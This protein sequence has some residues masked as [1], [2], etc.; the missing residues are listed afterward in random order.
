M[1]EEQAAEN[2][3]T[4][5]TEPTDPTLIGAEAS[6]EAAET[7]AAPAPEKPSTRVEHAYGADDITV[8]AIRLSQEPESAT[9]QENRDVD[10]PDRAG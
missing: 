6:A 1:A 7:P 5:P 9:V 3:G 10:T 8:L 4:G 2:N